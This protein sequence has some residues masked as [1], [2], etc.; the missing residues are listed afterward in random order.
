MDRGKVSFSNPVR[1]PLFV[2][3]DCLNGGKYKA[4]AAAER[5]KEIFPKIN[6]R[7]INASIPMPGHVHLEEKNVIQTQYETLKKEIKDHDV[8]F[9]LTDSVESRWLPSVLAIAHKKIVINVALGF[10]QYLVM[11]YGHLDSKEDRLGCYF[12]QDVTAP[13]N[14][15]K[16]RT[17][18]QQCTVTRPGGSSIASSL[19]IEM[20]VSLLHHPQ[21]A[22]V[23]PLNDYTESDCGELGVIPHQIRGNLADMQ[24]YLVNSTAYPRCT[25]CS[26]TILQQADDFE[27]MYQALLHPEALEELTGLSTLK[28]QLDEKVEEKED[29]FFV[30]I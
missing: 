9:L 6:A 29:D 14:T 27:K 5:L 24:N 4:L 21:G 19:A 1:Q 10:H 11:R 25:A 3:Q 17:L 7:G 30:I 15:L 23:K 16:D 28:K 20:L 12:C 22:C 18:D 13:T 2:Y 26:P 8:I